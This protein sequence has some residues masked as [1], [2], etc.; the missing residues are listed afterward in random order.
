MAWSQFFVTPWANSA[1]HERKYELLMAQL[2]NLE[3]DDK[4][5]NLFS[6]VALFTTDDAMDLDDKGGYKSENVSSFIVA[7]TSA[8]LIFPQARLTGCVTNFPPFCSVTS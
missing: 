1:E 5:T 3:L 6:V 7:S 4:S 2:R 8:N